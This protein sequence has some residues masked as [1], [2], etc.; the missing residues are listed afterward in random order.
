MG[1]AIGGITAGVGKA[2]GL[3]DEVSAASSQQA[4]GIGQVTTAIAKIAANASHHGE[5]ASNDCMGFNRP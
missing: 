3:I 2:K 5:S 4:Q 1:E